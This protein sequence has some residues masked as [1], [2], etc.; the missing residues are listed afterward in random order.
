MERP[1]KVVAP[2]DINPVPPASSHCSLRVSI[3]IAI[4]FGLVS[5]LVEIGILALEKR[6]LYPMMRLSRDFVWMASMAEVTLLL[7]AT[8]LLMV[9]SRLWDKLNLFSSVVFVCSLLAFLNLLMLVPRLHHVAALV[10]AAG[11]AIQAS[12]FLRTRAN[13]FHVVV[14]RTVF[15]MIGA[16]VV[17]GASVQ[18]QEMLAQREAI[19]QLSPAP[20]DAPNVLFITLD[21][22]RAANLSLYGYTRT[23]SLHIDRL[24]QQGVFFEHACPTSSWTLPSHVSLLTG[25][26][27]YDHGVEWK[28]ENALLN[29]KYPTLAEALR[30]HGY[31]TG[32]FSSNLFWFT[33]D[34]GFD[35][36][37]IRFEDYFQSID[38]MILRTLY[39][40]LIE[41]FVLRRLGFEDIPAR[42]RASDINRA[43]LH[44][45]ERD[46]GNPFFVFLTYMDTHDPYLPPEPYR[47]RFSNFKS[48]GGILN[49]RVGRSQPKMTQEQLQGESTPTTALSPT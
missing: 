33:R 1:G 42:R 40:R 4:W 25:R 13:L 23:T 28:T 14:R 24:A 29:S 12:R 19:A 36:G 5:G 39:G 30:S 32:G 31:R 16:V 10:L 43:T 8:L 7:L 3:L 26:Y 15:W 34:R 44:W 18:G 37:F 35:R 48:P 45:I 2:G 11:L 6:Y 20:K 38:D 21:T 47:S 22:V 17:L 27:V 41:S 9:A 49:W 46:R